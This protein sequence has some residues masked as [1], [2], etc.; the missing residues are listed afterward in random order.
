MP[1]AM[2]LAPLRTHPLLPHARQLILQQPPQMIAVPARSVSM[3]SMSAVLDGERQ[4]YPSLHL[5]FD[6]LNVRRC[7]PDCSPLVYTTPPCST[8]TGTGYPTVTSEPTGGCEPRT[9]CVD[10]IDP[11][12]Q[13]YGG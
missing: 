5:I 11:C 3:A 7:I 1:D 12:G 2:I 8:G 6:V 13:M 4:Y 10:M 9:L